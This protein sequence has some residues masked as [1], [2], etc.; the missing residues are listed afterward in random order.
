MQGAGTHLPRIKVSDWAKRPFPKQDL[1]IVGEAYSLMRG[2]CEGAL[3]SAEN[4]LQEGWKIDILRQRREFT[5]ET[6]INNK[7]DLTPVFP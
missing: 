6:S 2:W 5:Q 1:F 3:Q 7:M 4:A